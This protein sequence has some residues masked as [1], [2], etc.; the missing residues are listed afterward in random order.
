[1]EKKIICYFYATIH[2]AYVV[3][4]LE[5]RSL[6]R[7]MKNLKRYQVKKKYDDLSEVFDHLVLRVKILWLGL[8]CLMPLSTLFQLYRD[9][10]FYWWRKLE[11]PKK[12]HQSVA[13]HLS[14]NVAWNSRPQWR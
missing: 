12:N 2:F 1:M 11:Y 8:W 13:S 3:I 4:I 5:L 7:D 14:H 10:K 9:G 6:K